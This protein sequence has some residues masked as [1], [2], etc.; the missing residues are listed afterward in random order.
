MGWHPEVLIR[1][2]RLDSCQNACK[3]Y[4]KNG[5]STLSFTHSLSLSCSVSISVSLSL[6]LSLSL[7]SC[8]F[9]L[10][11]TLRDLESTVLFL[12]YFGLIYHFFF[13]LHCLCPRTLIAKVLRA[14]TFHIMKLLTYI[15][16]LTKLICPCKPWVG[17]FAPRMYQAQHM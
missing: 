13:F 5:I 7:Q 12:E 16:Y 14:D 2:P 4:S 1:S 11:F 9:T 15:F 3:C 10:F 8:S 6:S 17:K